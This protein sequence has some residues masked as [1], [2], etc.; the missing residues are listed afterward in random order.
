MI[1]GPRRP[2]LCLLSRTCVRSAGQC[3]RP[4]VAVSALVPRGRAS[5]GPSEPLAKLAHPRHGQP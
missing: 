1:L 4:S 2:C 5:E 3:A